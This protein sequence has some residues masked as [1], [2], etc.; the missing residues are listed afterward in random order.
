MQWDV[1]APRHERQRRHTCLFARRSA[2]LLT[3]IRQR[4]CSESDGQLRSQAQRVVGR[5]RSPR[6]AALDAEKVAM[7]TRKVWIRKSLSFWKAARPGAAAQLI[8]RN[9]AEGTLAITREQSHDGRG[10]GQ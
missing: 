10:G 2:V 3:A 8:G 9:A 1:T 6:L 4:V 5:K 7:R